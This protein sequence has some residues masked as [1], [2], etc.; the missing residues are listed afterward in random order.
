MDRKRGLERTEH[1]IVSAASGPHV[2]GVGWTALRIEQTAG[3]ASCRP[4]SSARSTASSV[5]RAAIEFLPSGSR[6]H[7]I[8]WA[9]RY[10]A[11]CGGQRTGPP[12]PAQLRYRVG[13][14]GRVRY[15]AE[16]SIARGADSMPLAARVVIS[17]P[18]PRS[19]R[20]RAASRTARSMPR[21]CVR[22]LAARVIRCPRAQK[23][24]RPATY[25]ARPA[26]AHCPLGRAR[27]ML[28]AARS[29]PRA[30]TRFRARTIK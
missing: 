22:P 4:R 9:A 15:R 28:R 10:R 24:A 12:D 1:V 5:R 27:S 3:A 14:A 6:A 19:A 7:N 16:R 8:E 21:A 18:H 20:Q 26:T 13:S 23:R 11:D 30:L 29:F 2:S 25:R 17:M